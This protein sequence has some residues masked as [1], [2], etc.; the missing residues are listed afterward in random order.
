MREFDLN[1]GLPNTVRK[2]KCLGNE[3]DI[4]ECSMETSGGGTR[5][6]APGVHCFGKSPLTDITQCS[7]VTSDPFTQY[8]A[9]GVHCFGKFSNHV[10]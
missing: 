1:G 2:L 4:T 7:M 10:N 6:A 3:S 5:Y 9:P 8:S